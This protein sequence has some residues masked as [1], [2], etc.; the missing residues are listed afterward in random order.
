MKTSQHY[1]AVKYQM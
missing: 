1:S